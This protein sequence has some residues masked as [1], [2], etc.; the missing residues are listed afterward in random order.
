MPKINIPLGLDGELDKTDESKKLSELIYNENR[1]NSGQSV[2]I[3]KTS[4][5]RYDTNDYPDNPEIYNKGDIGLIHIFWNLLGG[6]DGFVVMASDINNINEQLIPA[7]QEKQGFMSP[8]DKAKV[9]NIP[10]KVYNINLLANSWEEYETDIF[11]QLVVI[12][13]LTPNCKVDFD[14]DVVSMENISSP[15]RPENIS[16][17]LYAITLS[18]PD[19]DIPIQATVTIIENINEGGE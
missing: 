19:V 4:Q 2:Y 5:I 18:P 7:T 6:P 15:I 17:T 1:T 12:P 11:R 3:S 16:G 13:N 14:T 9:D 8:E 10:P